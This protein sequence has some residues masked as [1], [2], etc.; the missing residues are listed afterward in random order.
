MK[1]VTINMKQM[2]SQKEVCELLK[3]ELD[4]PDDFEGGLDELYAELL[5]ME[6]NTC[7]EMI[8]PEAGSPL[9]SF[10]KEM[11]SVVERAARAGYSTRSKNSYRSA[12]GR[13]CPQAW[14]V[15]FKNKEKS[16]SEC[17]LAAFLHR[18]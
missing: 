5:G 14:G 16:A 10:G 8:Q 2:E 18:G 15:D 13:V 4:F 6:E 1:M 3:R 9:E 7:V 12:G 11:E 17:L